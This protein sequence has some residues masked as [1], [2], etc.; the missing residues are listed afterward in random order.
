VGPEDRHA[1]AVIALA[2]GMIVA[3]T[4]LILSWTPPEWMVRT[5]F[6]QVLL[7]LAIGQVLHR[8]WAPAGATLQGAFLDWQ[9]DRTAVTGRVPLWVRKPLAPPQ[10]RE[11]FVWLRAHDTQVDARRP[12]PKWL[13]VPGLVIVAYLVVT[14]LLAKYGIAHGLAVPFLAPAGQ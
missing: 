6:Q 12:V 10:L 7:G 14:G 2:I 1:I 4:W 13:L 3:G 11:R 9:V 5:Q 8:L